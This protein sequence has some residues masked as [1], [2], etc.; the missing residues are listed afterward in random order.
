MSFWP[1]PLYVLCSCHFDILAWF[2]V[3]LIILAILSNFGH[4]PRMV[5]SYILLQIEWVLFVGRVQQGDDKMQHFTQNTNLVM[6]SSVF[7]FW[8]SARRDTGTSHR[9]SVPFLSGLSSGD[10]RPKTSPRTY[11]AVRAH[12]QE[13]P[14]RNLS[15]PYNMC[16]TP[17]VFSLNIDKHIYVVRTSRRFWVYRTSLSTV[18]LNPIFL[19]FPKTMSLESNATICL[20]GKAAYILSSSQYY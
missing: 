20:I 1:S 17:S 19:A 5:P 12:Q 18:S 2:L 6:M 9:F 8:F 14:T 3:I 16:V 13:T 7:C 4:T 11:T 10:E 15:K